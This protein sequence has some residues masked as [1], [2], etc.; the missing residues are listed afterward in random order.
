MEEILIE[1][2][3]LKKGYK[4]RK[5]KEWVQAVN[6]VN[7]TV[8]RGEILGLL[9]PNGAGKTTTIKMI[10]GLIV[11]DEGEVV[12]NGITMQKNRLKGLEHISAVLEGNRNLY[13]RLTARENLEYFA[14][15]RGN[16]RKEK[17]SEIEELLHEFKLKQKENELV[18]NLSRGMQQKLALA[19]ALLADSDVIL[20]DEPTLGLDIETGYEV[21][22]LLKKI[23]EAGKTIII[24]THDMPVV[25]DLCERTVIINDGKVIA[26]EKVEELMNLFETSVYV[27]TLGNELTEQQ[28][29]ELDVKFPMN[30][31]L[32]GMKL[33]ITLEQDNDIYD[34]M[35]LLK[36]ENTII[37]KIDRTTINFEEV[38]MNLIQ[39]EKNHAIHSI[40]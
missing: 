39:E 4:K 27:L 33:T 37:E 5:T 25:Q 28:Q 1:V 35:D 14:G 29:K 26:D 7:F 6:D 40:N 24:S 9:G 11:P 32:D 12:I 17:A 3:G 31:L 2:K 21:R 22:Q 18:S 19:V 13:W 10:C 8:K 36:K 30:E 16:S 15:N 23:S 20:L 34:L 38:F